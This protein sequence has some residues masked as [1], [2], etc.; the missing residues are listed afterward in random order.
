MEIVAGNIDR[1]TPQ[2]F[3]PPGADVN[4]PVL[5]LEIALDE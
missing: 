2:R 1:Y 3:Y 4:D 5:L